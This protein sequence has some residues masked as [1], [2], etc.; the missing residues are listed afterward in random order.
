MF[1]EAE[2]SALFPIYLTSINGYRVGKWLIEFRG[3]YDNFFG[4]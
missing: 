1:R 3:D 4:F 2:N